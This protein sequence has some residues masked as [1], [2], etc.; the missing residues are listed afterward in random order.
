M[1]GV[2]I[3][4]MLQSFFADKKNSSLADL[5]YALRTDVGK[6]ALDSDEIDY[7]QLFK[8]DEN[9]NQV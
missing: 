8:E 2:Q 4:A 9:A 7:M 1:S 3:K 5:C 6:L